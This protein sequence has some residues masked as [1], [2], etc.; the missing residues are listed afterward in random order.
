MVLLDAHAMMTTC[1]DHHSRG[2]TIRSSFP[3]KLHAAQ[4]G[5]PY[6]VKQAFAPKIR[7][8]NVH[9]FN[10]THGIFCSL[11]VHNQVRCANRVI[12]SD[13]ALISPVSARML[14]PTHV[15]YCFGIS[16][17]LCKRSLLFCTYQCIHRSSGPLRVHR[18][19]RRTPPVAVEILD[20]ERNNNPQNPCASPAS[21]WGYS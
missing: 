8:L 21:S 7:L 3:S 6:A 17:C 2:H 16:M 9:R 4:R 11:I 10:A 14:A 13:V 19:P 12:L 5:R 20:V 15:I 1:W 18:L